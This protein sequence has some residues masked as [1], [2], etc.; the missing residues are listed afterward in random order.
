MWKEGGGGSTTDNVRQER[1]LW[2][3]NAWVTMQSGQRVQG[4]LIRDKRAGTI[5][6]ETHTRRAR[7]SL[8]GTPGPIVSSS[9]WL[10]LSLQPEN[11]TNDPLKSGPALAGPAG[12]ATPPLSV[13]N[14]VMWL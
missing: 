5:I 2:N 3:Q 14:C 11:G 7:A 4:L 13:T 10:R 9:E 6:R 8:C 12:L 1:Y